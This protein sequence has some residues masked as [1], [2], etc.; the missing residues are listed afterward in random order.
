ML[1]IAFGLY[2]LKPVRSVLAEAN[3]WVNSGSN[4][5]ANVSGNVGIGTV[6]PQFPLHLSRGTGVP[7]GFLN[8]ATAANN[9][10]FVTYKAA[11]NTSGSRAFNFNTGASTPNRLDLRLLNDAMTSSTRTIMTWEDNGSVGIGITNPVFTLDVHDPVD[12]NAV[13]WGDYLFSY[14]DIT[15]NLYTAKISISPQFLTVASNGGGTPATAT[16]TITNAYVEITCNDADGCNITLSESGNYAAEPVTIVNTSGY[17]VNFS[18]TSG[19]SEL[20][21]SCALGRW[22]T[23][24]LYYEGSR[25]VETDRS[26]N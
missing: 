1:I 6:S 5:Y 25:W 24:T 17:T 18:D 11:A 4:M 7:S 20:A 14:Y 10:A 16:L 8:E 2:Q 26:N 15:Q 3:S 12:E 23:L 13:I 9:D 21:G 19:V 22:D